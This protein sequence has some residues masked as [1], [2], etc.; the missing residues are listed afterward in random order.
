MAYFKPSCNCYS[1]IIQVESE[2][3]SGEVLS[4]RLKT[5]LL[6]TFLHR[7]RR[8]IEAVPRLT[9]L[10]LVLMNKLQE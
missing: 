7:L 6:V 10:S 4:T 5:K 1:L 9:I 2:S 3:M 8:C